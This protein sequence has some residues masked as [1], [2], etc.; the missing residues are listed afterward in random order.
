MAMRQPRC[1][2][3]PRR[4]IWR[5]RQQGTSREQSPTDEETR[6]LVSVEEENHGGAWPWWG[7]R[8]PAV[9]RIQ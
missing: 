2:T 3:L 6:V 7:R 5:E 8:E 1:S 4:R 9:R